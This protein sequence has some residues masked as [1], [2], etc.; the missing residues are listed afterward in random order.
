MSDVSPIPELKPEIA[1]IFDLL[2]QLSAGAI[3]VPRFQ[4]PFV[5]RRAQ[6]LDLL[7]SIKRQY[8]IGSLLAWETDETIASLSSIGPIA[9]GVGFQST[10]AYLLDGHQRLSTLAGALVPVESPTPAIDDDPDR[11]NIVYDAAGDRFE[12]LA[13]GLLPG[14]A[15]FPLTRLL[16]TVQ[17]LEECQRMLAADEAK[18]RTH[19][20]RVQVIARAFQNYKIPIIRIRDTGLT[21]AVEIFA[22]L[23]SKGQPM[24]ADQMVSALLYREGARKFDLSTE[25]DAAMAELEARG[26]EGVDRA[27]VLRTLLAASG[28]AIYRTDWTRIAVSRRE[29]LLGRLEASVPTVKR[30][31]VHAI[32]FLRSECGV[33]NARLL[34]YAMQLV[35]LASFFFAQPNPSV[36][37]VDLLR[38]W[39]W[40]SSFGSWFG[41]T[42][43]SRV[44]A[45][46]R[47]VIDTLAANR[48]SPDLTSFDLTA[49]AQPMSRAF[50]MRSARTRATV[51]V[52]LSLGPRGPN[53]EL[54]ERPDEL[55]QLYGPEAVAHIVPTSGGVALLSSPGNR[56]IR[57]SRGER[58]QARVWLKQLEPTVQTAVC[59]SH[60]IPVEALSLL[61]SS[62]G[63]AFVAARLA[64]LSEVEREFMA[65]VGVAAPVS[66]TPGPLI[67]DVE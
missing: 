11:W 10:P 35:V 15:Q 53:G 59:D 24:T 43:P 22:R 54:V 17:F 16:D 46:V 67:I 8:P 14:P 21:E 36:A 7:D 50:D 38:R 51:L 3:R 33:T 30:S 40:V 42:N 60:A 55:I 39:F 27:V 2:R 18:G 64:R 4:R 49:P 28:E 47:E 25:I 32:E 61:D 56:L 19:V 48:E 6:M 13:S 29:D 20:A 34:P 31:L 5:W 23:N 1:F 65:G 58:G 63:A 26:F 41:G 12:H 62:D 44:N 45:L 52:L 57:P 37:Q 9:V 66:D